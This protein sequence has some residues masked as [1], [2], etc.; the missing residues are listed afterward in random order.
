MESY[1]E[2]SIL[3][4]LFHYM[5]RA[6]VTGVDTWGAISKEKNEIEKAPKWHSL[7]EFQTSLPTSL[8]YYQEIL[9]KHKRVSKVV[10]EF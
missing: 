9:N 8:R 2:L 10:N 4:I 5:F 7:P 1:S 3:Q 6:T